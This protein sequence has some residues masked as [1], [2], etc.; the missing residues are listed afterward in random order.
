MRRESSGPI[1]T[2][3]F[4]DYDNIYL[5][6]RRK[7]EEAAKRFA[8]D[9]SVWL[10]ELETGRL[11]TSTNGIAPTMPR[12]IVM[13]RCYGNPVPRRNNS[14]NSTDMNSFPFVRHHF[15][16]SGF[17]VI[18]CPPLTAQLKNSSDIRMVMDVRDLLGHDTY[19]DEFIILSGDA[20]FT[21][22]LHR[23]R[24]H[25]RR[26][27]IFAN[28]HTAAPYTS[29]SD[30]EV[31]EADLIS[32]LLDG[33]LAS[34]PENNALATP[35]DEAPRVPSITQIEL[36]R[37]ELVTEVAALV[38]QAGQPVPLEALADRLVRTL[39]HE[40]TVGTGWGGTGSFRDLLSRALPGELRLSG[41]APYYVYDA[42]QRAIGEAARTGASQDAPLRHDGSAQTHSGQ[43]NTGQAKAQPAAT[44]ASGDRAGIGMTSATATS[45]APQMTATA[46]P[47]AAAGE[48]SPGRLMYAEPRFD[49]MPSTPPLHAPAQQSAQ[50]AAR[51]AA[52]P[53]QPVFA[54]KPA[55][56]QAPA[57]GERQPMPA[58][59]PLTPQPAPLHR[60]SQPAAA[61]PQPQ[62]QP[63]RAS[64]AANAIQQSITRIHEACQAPPLSPPEYRALFEAMAQEITSNG[65]MGA[66]TLTN[67]AGRAQEL[68]LDVRRDDIR[69]VLEVV[70]EADPW[71][72]QGASALLFSS[73]FR[74]F[75]VARCRSQGL[76]LSSNELDLI[77]AWFAGGGNTEHPAA[78]AQ[79]AAPGGSATA[80]HQAAPAAPQ[81]QPASAGDRWWGLDEPRQAAG[82]G[83]DEFPRFVR[84]G[85]RR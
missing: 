8:K 24:A 64:D 26:T 25:A 14:D 67:I 21:P 9:A 59:A 39:G 46:M 83:G 7:S 1:L 51:P 56:P 40:K 63:Q 81:L 2:T 54:S 11:I 49:A 6:L 85:L 28:D 50:P 44:L 82:D 12:R 76:N 47:H 48:P 68:G 77:E 35:Q 74:N 57:T 66:Q 36:I 20:D 13:N 53:A 5:S 79:P 65:L 17:E 33:R 60:P 62:P 84:K 18:D 10:R 41:E 16:R 80:S 31:R 69:F 71:F 55:A 37:R 75:V 52:A 22:V 42:G 34:D 15:L 32:L 3:I 58:M 43:A 29:I 19:F 4:V 27:V 78:P 38:R 70:S 61:A 30:G 23:L 72:A 73:R 45:A